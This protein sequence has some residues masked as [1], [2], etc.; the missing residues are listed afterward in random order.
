MKNKLS[1]SWNNFVEIIKR[2]EMSI[3][4]GHLAYYFLISTIPALTLIFY[5][6]SLLNLPFESVSNFV[7]NIFSKEV[8]NMLI[9]TITEASLNFK[10]ILFVLLAFYVTSNGARSII[11]A[12]NSIF[13]IKESSLIKKRIKSFVLTI[14]LILLITFILVVPL[15]G[16]K[17]LEFFT[18]INLNNEI[19]SALNIIYPVLKWPLTLFVVFL[20]I[21]IIYTM[22]PDELIP[23]S[24]VNKGAIFTTI[25]WTII[26][27]IYSFYINNIADYTL[28]YGA[29]SNIVILILWF[30]LISYIFVIGLALNYKNIESEN[31]KTNTIKLKEIQDKIR[32]IKKGKKLK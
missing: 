1:E 10:N 29:L 14:F 31:E 6:A 8:T 23:S 7:S 13:N 28:L 24:Y 12:S 19:V 27:G 17:I 15:F 16:N 3:L 25:S 2:K 9:T 18:L 30:W 32:Q 22:S 20:F 5:I 21:K 4:P 11:T 26:T